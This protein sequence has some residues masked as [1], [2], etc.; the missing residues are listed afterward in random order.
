MNPAT[1]KRAIVMTAWVAL[2]VPILL[3]AQAQN[4]VITNLGTLG[5]TSSAAISINDSGLISGYSYQSGNQTQVAVIFQNGRPVSLGTLGGPNSGVEWPNHN[6]RAVVGIAETADLDPLNEN[7]SCSSFFPQPPTGHVCLGFVWQNG[8][9]NPLRTLGGIN[10]YAAG[11]NDV[12]QVVGWAETP[13]HDST[14]VLP[15]V[16]QFE[17]VIWG[18]NPGQIQQLSP[19]YQDPDSAATAINNQGQVVGISG[20]CENAVGDMSATHAVF[21]ENGTITD[22]KSLGGSAWN[23][24]AAIND[25]GQVVGFSENTSSNIHAFFWTRGG[26]IQDLKT[27][28]GDSDSYAYAINERG[29]VVG[30]SLGGPYGTRAFI[31]ENGVMTDLNCLTPPGSPYLLYAND[32]DDS[33]RITGEAY[34]PN[35]GEAPAF[36]ATPTPGV[37]HCSASSSAAPYGRNPAF[38]GIFPRNVTAILQRSGALPK[39]APAQ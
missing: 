26:G 15:Q 2:I 9:M 14:C 36:V 4:Y 31:W 34:D 33:G 27:I 30:Q 21:W 6:A 37:N 18:P 16:L 12:G 3:A 17:A 10:G 24:P 20:I 8:V 25:R 5:G 7:W 13:V 32:I 19:I 11:A 1:L 29:Q 28:D 35:T 22:L 23:T 39:S 38:N